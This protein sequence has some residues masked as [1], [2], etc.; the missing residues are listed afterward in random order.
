MCAIID[1]FLVMYVSEN[2]SDC[3]NTTACLWQIVGNEAHEK[4][5]LDSKCESQIMPINLA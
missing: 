5:Q 4:K 2:A 1:M 3:Q